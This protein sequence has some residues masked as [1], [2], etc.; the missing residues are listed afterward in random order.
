MF[1][2]AVFWVKY[3]DNGGEFSL[4]VNRRHSLQAYLHYIL[5]LGLSMEGKALYLITFRAKF[6]EFPT[7][8]HS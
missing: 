1:D 2:R 8:L 3:L 5:T 7:F 6:A 4:V